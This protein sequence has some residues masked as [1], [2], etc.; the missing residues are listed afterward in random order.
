MKYLYGCDVK[1]IQSYI[2]DSS[3]LKEIAGASELVDYVCTELFEEFA[4]P[5]AK[6]IIGAAG[7]VRA[8]FENI[9]DASRIMRGFPKLVDETAE[10][11]QLVQSIVE[12]G[13]SSITKADVDKLE[14]LLAREVPMVSAIKDWS[15]IAKA[16]RSGRP[17]A[18]REDG[19]ELDLASW[20]KLKAVKEKHWKKL[21]KRFGLGDEFTFPSDAGKISGTD[22]LLAVIHADGNSLGQTLM[23]LSASG[24][25]EE[26]W[27]AFSRELDDATTEAAKTAYETI[28]SRKFRPI[29]LG[30]DDLTVICSADDAVE[31]TRT[32]LEAF[33]RETK[34]RE[35]LG[36]LTA[37][38][39][40]AF[41]KENYP[42]HFG[43]ELAEMLCNEAKKRAKEIDKVHVPSCLMFSLELGSFIEK[44]FQSIRE[45]RLTAGNTGLDFG[46]YK[47]DGAI[48]MPDISD[49]IAAARCLGLCNPLKN[50]IRRYI[51]ELHVNRQSADFLAERVQQIAREKTENIYSDFAVCLGR[52]TGVEPGRNLSDL[53][54]NRN[55]RT[56]ALD[57]LVLSKFV[58]KEQ[59]GENHD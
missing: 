54:I 45:R 55:G 48:D 53:L 50:G 24:D 3:R 17:V 16:P 1:K 57:L 39:G 19:E 47:T 56:P 10:G 11:L 18:R 15:V 31:F 35:N 36:E 38:A 42:F 22:S 52:L 12:I 5:P 25:Y 4:G 44:D 26:K 30:G 34:A 59:G 49:L 7:K 28:G 23:K 33:R 32:Y 43:L 2:S 46:P 13:G 41:I 21:R 9:D 6:V 8:V 20:Q 40:I 37:C 29:I 27:K 58:N 14:L 51:S